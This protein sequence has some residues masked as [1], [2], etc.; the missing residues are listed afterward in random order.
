MEAI[1]QPREGEQAEVEHLAADTGESIESFRV[2]FYDMNGD[3]A[4][5]MAAGSCIHQDCWG[6]V[7]VRCGEDLYATVW[8]GDTVIDVAEGATEV[9]GVPWRNLEI[10]WQGDDCW[11]DKAMRFDGKTYVEVPGTTKKSECQ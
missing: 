2:T 11:M 10:G 4:L 5:D 9:A 8:S 7:H 1:T 6:A 3:G